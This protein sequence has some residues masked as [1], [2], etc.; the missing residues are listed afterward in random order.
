[1]C[2]IV[3][4][5][6]YSQPV[7]EFHLRAA[8]NAIA[9]RG[10][11]DEGIYIDASGCVGFAQRRLSII[12]LSP[13]GHQPMVWDSPQGAVV[14]NFNGEIYNYK[15][16][17]RE[18]ENAAR[19]RFGTGIQWR[20]TSDTEVVLW[21][22]LLWG[23]KCLKLLD[24]MFAVAIWDGRTR[25]LLVGRDRFGVK[26]L[27]YSVSGDR[28][29]FAS[30]LK[31][32]LEFG[33]VDRR[34]D[35]MAVAQYVTFLFTPGRRTML[36]AVQKLEAG[37]LA[38]FDQTKGFR[39]QRFEAC[40]Q[41][42]PIDR[43]YTEESAAS[44]LRYLLEQA[45][46]KQMIADVPVGAFLSGGLD[47]SSIVAFAR[48]RVTSGRLQ[49][50]TIGYEGESRD[51]GGWA[52]D[53][54]YA[55]RV[56]EHL[57]VDLSTVW[58]GPSM[59]SRFSWMVQ[60]LDE[61]SAD[62][63]ALNAY[64]ICNMA[65][66]RGV[67]V[68]LSGAGGDDLFSGYR[69]HRALSS[70]NWWSWMPGV[71]RSGLS[72]AARIV[73]QRRPI[74]RRF[75]KAFQYA[76]VSR[77]ERLVGYFRW[78]PPQFAYSIFDGAVRR[79]VME[80]DPSQPMLDSLAALPPNT[81][82]LR[83]ML[84]LDGRYFLVDQNLNYTDKMSMASGVEVRVPFLD[85][86]LARFA[87]SLPSSYLQRGATG[88]WIFRKAMEPVLPSDVIYRSKTGFG[89]PLRSWLQKE[90]LG[91]VNDILSG[92]RLRRRGFFNPTAVADLLKSDREGRLDATYVIFA[93]MCVETWCER[94]GAQMD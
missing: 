20:G 56:A 36:Q 67:K 66:E 43:S 37:E 9:H 93:L 34:V 65:R 87:A 58:V 64:F 92:D 4:I 62:P 78:L 2:G 60:Q 35:H 24:G 80:E 10:P 6:S 19:H 74:G 11:D 13:A 39:I 46:E 18:C 53:L 41:P 90:L 32:L 76:D 14:L 70:E 57:G 42:L 75:A 26:P 12:D 45:V 8:N 21:C 73:N 30:E 16:L 47:S 27:Y 40:Y 22:Y 5:V 85:P 63:A 25:S 59:A 50:F 1:M 55:K 61:P 79:A 38:V 7:S 51:E 86:A 89:V 23:E 49:C 28:M 29:V 54:P 17:R 82:Q 69:R 52:E 3:G 48:S 15:L 94:F 81:D 83:R 84:H 44:R 68:L 72:S 71:C 88:K 77:E 33:S 31:A 91:E